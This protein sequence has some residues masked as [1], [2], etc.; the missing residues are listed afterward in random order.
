MT[1][2]MFVLHRVVFY[3]AILIGAAVVIAVSWAIGFTYGVECCREK[4][5]R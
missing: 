2:I 4:E 5:K 1:A 3:L